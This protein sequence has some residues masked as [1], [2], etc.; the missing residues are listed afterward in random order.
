MTLWSQTLQL[1]PTV[2]RLLWSRGIETLADAESFLIEDASGLWDPFLLFDMDRTI[3]RLKEAIEREERIVIYGDYDVDGIS[4]TALLMKAF[5]SLG[6]KVDFYLPDRFEEGYGL[7]SEA[8]AR[9]AEQGA[10]VI[11][12]VD[13]GISAV[14]QAKEAKELGICLIITDH[15]ECQGEIPEAFAV[16]NPKQTRCE[17]PEKFLAGAGIALKVAQALLGESFTQQSDALFSL[18]ALG[19]IA[20]LAPLIGE[21]RTLAKLGLKAINTQPSLGLSALMEVAGIQKKTIT[22]GHIGFQIGPRLNASGRLDKANQG[23]ELLLSEELEYCKSI[24][25]ELNALNESRQQIEAEM[26]KH[27]IS[28]IEEQYGEKL[29]KILVLSDPEFHVGVVGIAASRLVERYCRP[30]IL[31]NE[32]GDILKG[33]ARSVG[34][35]NIFEAISSTQDHLINFGGHK[36]AAGLKLTIETY[37]AFYEALLVYTEAHITPQDLMP[38]F[39]IDQVLKAQDLTLKLAD[40]LERLEPFGMG[41]PKPVFALKQLRLEGIKWMGTE[42]QHL[43]LMLNT[44]DR[45]FEAIQ[46]RTQFQ[47]SDFKIHE[48][49]DVAFQVDK[50]DY[51][52]VETLQLMI[53]DLKMKSISTVEKSALSRA[54]LLA[55]LDDLSQ[56]TWE[57]LTPEDL[58]PIKF[59]TDLPDAQEENSFIYLLSSIIDWHQNHPGESPTIAQFKRLCPSA[60]QIVNHQGPLICDFVPDPIRIK[61]ILAKGGRFQYCRYALQQQ[62]DF[63]ESILM[64]RQALGQIYLKAVSQFAQKTFTLDEWQSQ[65]EQLGLGAFFALRLFADGGLCQMS[66]DH[67]EMVSKPQK[68]NMY[69]LPLMI[70]IKNYLSNLK[71]AIELDA[72]N[73]V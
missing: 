16:I 37:D 53:K 30:V 4:S 55:L 60:D 71:L 57:V 23:V 5:S 70:H 31:M 52:S 27:C 59:V 66:G 21:N 6:A 46:F 10:Q 32:E 65:F 68:I 41:N 56:S 26:V 28:T 11:I 35:F 62:I 54:Y 42:R 72:G 48:L 64:E 25:K 43:K 34:E 36:Q 2:I 61:Y 13:C 18:S 47:E 19:T 12:T 69:E 44:E 8:L 33:S 73:K 17:Y 14:K 50:N 49:L 20:D 38:R 22:A 45:L 40:A 24:A 51:R 29:P 15:H 7:N 67:F 9:L 58:M 1:P 63:I 3:Q 39:N